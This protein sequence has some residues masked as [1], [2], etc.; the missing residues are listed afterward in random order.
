[1]FQNLY[2]SFFSIVLTEACNSLC[3][4]ANKLNQFAFRAREMSSQEPVFSIIHASMGM[5]CR[6]WWLLLWW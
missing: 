6:S 3:L 5:A 1:M 4:L 2:E